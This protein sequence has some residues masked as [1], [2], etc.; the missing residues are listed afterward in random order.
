M[1]R[2]VILFIL[3]AQAAL[4]FLVYTLL[5]LQKLEITLI[6]PRILVEFGLFVVFSLS[7]M[8]INLK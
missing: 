3:F 6:H 1:P 8:Y 2:P 5:N 7:A 4:A